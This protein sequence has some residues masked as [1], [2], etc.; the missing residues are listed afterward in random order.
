MPSLPTLVAFI[1]A[2]LVLALTPGPDMLML[3]SRGV[4]QGRRTALYT[5]LGFTAAG[6]IQLPLLVLGLAALVQHSSIGFGIIKYAGAVYLIWRGIQLISSRSQVQSLRVARTTPWLAL[7]D[8]IVASLTNP[9]GLIFLLAFL[10]Q[11]VD[12]ARGNVALQ[13]VLL[14]GIMKIT[15]LLVEGTVAVGAGAIGEFLAQRPAFLRWQQ[16]GTGLVMVLLGMRL[17]LMRDVK[18]R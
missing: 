15:A 1:G 8:G 17:L 18:A 16:R 10:P 3:I 2:V 7:R 11:F 6:I 4:G 9:K 5:A 13:L 14:G 12:P